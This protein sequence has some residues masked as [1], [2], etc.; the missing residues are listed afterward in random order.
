MEYI[1]SKQAFSAAFIKV[2]RFWNLYTAFTGG[3]G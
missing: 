1:G 2:P 3:T